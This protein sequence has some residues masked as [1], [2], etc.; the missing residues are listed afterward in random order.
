MPILSMRWGDAYG[1]LAIDG[2]RQP[3][4]AFQIFN[5]QPAQLLNVDNLSKGTAKWCPFVFPRGT[6][7]HIAVA[8]D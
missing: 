5:G 2:V 3:L 1:E 4:K 6:S 7:P 8:P